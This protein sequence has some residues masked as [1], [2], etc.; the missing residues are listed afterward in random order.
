MTK[1][2]LISDRYLLI[3][4]ASSVEKIQQGGMASIFKAID[5]STG[6]ECALKI[7]HTNI[8]QTIAKESFERERSAL[9]KLSSPQSHSNI[10]KLLNVGVT[11]DNSP[12]LVL[13][14]I[15]TTL[16]EWIKNHGAFSSWYL[17]YDTIGR[18]ILDAIAFAHKRDI[19]HRD[20]KPENILILADIPKVIDFG[21]ARSGDLPNVATLMHFKSIPYAPEA[22]NSR[23]HT[24]RDCY[25]WAVI[26]I[27]CMKGQRF[28][29]EP[30]VRTALDELQFNSP[31]ADI[32]SRAIDVNPANRFVRADE[33]SVEL[34]RYA[35]DQAQ[36]S[37]RI[38]K[39]F[40]T[41]SNDAAESGRQLFFLP[42]RLTLEAALLADLNE[43]VSVD[44]LEQDSQLI[45]IVG[46]AW[47]IEAT[48]SHDECRYEIRRFTRLRPGEAERR[49]E[50]CFSTPLCFSFGIP[51]DRIAAKRDI[52][53]LRLKMSH[54]LYEQEAR[55]KEIEK[56]RI[57][58]LWFAF[59][60]A[61]LSFERKKC[62]SIS[63]SKI[64]I[65]D[66]RA[67]LS[68]GINLGQ[69]IIGEERLIRA[70]S[71]RPI[72]CVVRGVHHGEVIVSLS[73]A[74]DFSRLPKQGILEA[75]IVAAE[76]AIERQ[77]AA[78]DAIQL[79][80]TAL[81]RLKELLVDASTAA[82]PATL[83]GLSFADT[84]LSPDKLEALYTAIALKECL[85]IHGPPGTGKTR[86]ITEIIARYLKQYPGHRVL[87]S[88][89]THTALD[90]VIEKLVELAPNVNIVRIGAYDEEKI[91]PKSRPFLLEEKV[92]TWSTNVRVRAHRFLDDVAKN[93]G[94]SKEEVEV[95]IL[96]EEIIASTHRQIAISHEIADLEVK[97]K[98][99]EETSN[100]LRERTAQLPSDEELGITSSLL[101]RIGDM[102]TELKKFKR[103]EKDSRNALSQLGQYGAALADKKI[104][105]MMEWSDV[106]LKDSPEGHRIKSLVTLQQE[107]LARLGY[108][109]DFFKHLVTEA[110]VV[111]C[112]CVGIAGLRDGAEIA[113]DL[114]IVDEASKAT[115]TE[116]LV[117]MSRASR[118]IVVGDPQQLPPF[119]ES[120]EILNLEGFA[121]DEVKQTIL[122]RWLS[123][124]PSHS[125]VYL[126]EQHRMVK[127]IGDL[128]SSVFYENKLNTTRMLRDKG[129]SKALKKSVMWISTSHL[130]TR[131][132]YE[133]GTGYSNQSECELVSKTLSLIDTHTRSNE[134]P[135][136]VAVIAGY[137]AQVTLLEQTIAGKRDAWRN[138]E[139]TCDTVDAFQGSEADVCIYSV[140]RSNGNRKFGFVKE[141]PRLNVALS[142]GRDALVI[143][144]D[145]NF[146]QEC[147]DEKSFGEVIAYI[148]SN[149]ETCEL[150][151][152]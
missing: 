35:Q 110:Q 128:I 25:S 66:G 124:L 67:I 60:Q 10:I 27:S 117:P 51:S 135:V 47:T 21:I 77:R 123:M 121:E 106:L 46:S 32:L 98:S 87:L 131:A 68:I 103:A 107:W 26:A 84:N 108:S 93:N 126:T 73:S 8:N 114:C 92:L 142:R 118:W 147:E 41:L 13:E 113:Y 100:K 125:K 130:E 109:E 74:A 29:T 116:A 55:Q 5:S 119:F 111:A 2:K 16:T 22:D 85:A 54:F 37:G 136:T 79:G 36:K 96:A 86:L 53:E 145:A 1:P 137:L 7:M 76:K 143:I 18:P 34:D 38:L 57:F 134:K 9:E 152:A 17:F 94:I 150:K 48:P 78:I 141:S 89:Q 19:A 70:S 88:A 4:N 69:E 139:I 133:E 33:L 102:K 127:D 149:S 129:V 44:L 148:E 40:L 97:V 30:E 72:P 144:G 95:G 11:D 20:I 115:A 3:Q 56:E 45:R 82:A 99:T 80:D 31:L 91:S 112:T 28:Q 105:D 120:R 151:N 65:A 140:T 90:N 62:K 49:R 101:G 81:K 23:F 42:D 50:H 83:P 122:D 138:L 14:W 15:P 64:H 61:K 39:L 43:I 12:Y 6:N 71:G 63:Y 59:L 146:C 24:S 75:N 58:R 52:A 104:D 132:E